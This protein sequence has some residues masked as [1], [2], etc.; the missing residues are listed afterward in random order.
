MENTPSV[1]DLNQVNGM[2][3][4][5]KLWSAIFSNAVE[6]IV[7]TDDKVNILLV[8]SAFSTV[9][10]YSQ[11]EVVGKNPRILKSGHHS[12]RF[13]EQMWESLAILGQWHGEI[14]NRRKDGSLYPELLNIIA[15]RNDTGVVTNYVGI[16]YDLTTQK[17]N[18]E[19]F[20]Y[21]ATH[22]QL[23]DL[24][25]RARFYDNL[26]MAVYEAKLYR[27][28]VAVLYIDLDGFKEVNDTYG[29]KLGDHLLISIA[30]RL[31]SCAGPR[32]TVARMGGDEFIVIL[33]NIDS[34]QKVIDTAQEILLQVSNPYDAEGHCLRVSASIGI[35][36]YPGQGAVADD[37]DDVEELLIRADKAM[38]TAKDQGGNSFQFYTK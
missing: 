24:P 34:T 31:L 38:Y 15:I 21:I 13:Y 30:E 27:H 23:T 2:I 36:L 22:D 37:L 32:D 3:N 25:N 11:N 17:D 10:G 28:Q 12:L 18:D 19:F 29:H 26:N 9:T 1:P 8:N 14:E 4:N 6:G 16:F 7:I 33:S 35:S 5:P 20:K